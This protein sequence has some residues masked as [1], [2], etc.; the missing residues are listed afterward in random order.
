MITLIIIL[1][2]IPNW[3]A[4]SLDFSPISPA[5]D[6]QKRGFIGFEGGLFN[7]YLLLVD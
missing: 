1:T 3:L 7:N 5:S 6:H 2:S 4:K